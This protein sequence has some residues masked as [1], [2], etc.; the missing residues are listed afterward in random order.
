MV[1]VL[2]PAPRYVAA[3]RTLIL[4]GLITL[5]VLSGAVAGHVLSP[6]EA[7]RAAVAG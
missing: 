2:Q 5:P 3:M 4:A 1:L 7:H 6:D